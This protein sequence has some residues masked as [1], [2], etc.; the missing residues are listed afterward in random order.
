MTLECDTGVS[1]YRDVTHDAPNDTR[2][3]IGELAE[4][5]GVSRRTVRFYVQRGLLAPPHGVGRGAYYD[6]THLQRLL[7]VKHAQERGLPL[8]AIAARTDGALPEQEPPPLSRTA[9][10]MEPW[11]RLT[12][13]PGVEL[14]VR[15]GALGR[16]ELVALTSA[17][18]SVLA[19]PSSPAPPPTQGDLE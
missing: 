18:G 12:L 10:T 4:A 2:Y 15:A 19:P 5:G 17:L 14:H 13:A 1:H 3:S 16:A 8:E 9:A 11:S 7:A 6:A